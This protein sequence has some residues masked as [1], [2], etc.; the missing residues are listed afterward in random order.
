MLAHEVGYDYGV[1]WSLRRSPKLG[2]SWRNW[3][4]T[5]PGLVGQVLLR[6]DRVAAAGRETQGYD[7]PVDN[8]MVTAGTTRPRSW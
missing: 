7:V 3:I 5:C 6:H 1:T 8:V 2:S 4:R